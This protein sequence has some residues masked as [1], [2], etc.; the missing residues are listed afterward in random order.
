GYHI[1][2]RQYRRTRRITDYAGDASIQLVENYSFIN[3][4]YRY[5]R[6]FM[7]TYNRWLDTQR[8]VMK[9]MN[10]LAKELPHRQQFLVVDLPQTLPTI[11][12][13]TKAR[14]GINRMILNLFNTPEKLMVL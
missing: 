3:R 6:H 5:P 2:N 11:S 1:E 4:R 7:A 10:E 14:L 8:T 9:R 12:E 13:L